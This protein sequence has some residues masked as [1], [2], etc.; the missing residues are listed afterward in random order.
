MAWSYSIFCVWNSLSL[1][2]IS[3]LNG[4]LFYPT[5]GT[6]NHKDLI[7]RANNKTTFSPFR[8]VIWMKMKTWKCLLAPAQATFS[9]LHRACN[10]RRYSHQRNPSITQTESP[11]M[12]PYLLRLVRH[13]HPQATPHQFQHF[14][15][16]YNQSH[17]ATLFIIRPL[18]SVSTHW[19]R[20]RLRFIHH[21][22]QSL[23]AL[24]MLSSRE[25][26]PRFLQDQKTTKLNR[27]IK[28]VFV[29]WWNKYICS[30]GSLNVYKL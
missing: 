19:T 24:R 17:P 3:I 21:Q 16:I 27:N 29:I 23:K 4:L 6:F 20:H 26:L 28:L 10:R 30:D 2:I 11:S 12:P 9:R 8:I 14:Q 5:K 13:R 18:R 7:W 25:S 15:L 22:R 1:L